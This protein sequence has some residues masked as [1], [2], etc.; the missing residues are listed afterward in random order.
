M[1][2]FVSASGSFCPPKAAADCQT[3][4]FLDSL[5]KIGW[6]KNYSKST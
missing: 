3:L 4:S 5:Y 1:A 2:M 6:N